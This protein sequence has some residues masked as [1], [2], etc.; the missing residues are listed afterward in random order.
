LASLGFWGVNRNGTPAIVPP[1]ITIP[2]G[3][4]LMGSDKA[5]DSQAHDDELPQHRVEASALQI[6]KYPVT[7]VEYALAVHAGAVREPPASGTVT[8]ANQQQHPD[9]PVVCVSWQDANAY[10]T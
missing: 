5:K 2:A 4:F 6:A 7:V 3:A 8:W 10:I 9:H 1:L